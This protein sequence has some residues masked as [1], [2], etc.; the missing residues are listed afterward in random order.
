MWIFLALVAVPIIEIALFIQVGGWIGLWPT[1]AI[2]ILT[3]AI[4]TMLLRQQGVAALG[5]LQSRLSEGRDPSH[6]LAHGAMILIA[7]IV[8]LTPGFFTDAVG[9]LLLIP[10]VRDLVIQAVGNRI[11]VQSASFHTSGQ[12]PGQT[13]AEPASQSVIDGD[14]QDVTPPEEQSTPGKSGWTKPG[15]D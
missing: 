5:D 1:I 13:P 12:W 10:P 4:G 8:L 15:G 3:A 11:R 2:V 7:G 9:F 6:A 14:Y